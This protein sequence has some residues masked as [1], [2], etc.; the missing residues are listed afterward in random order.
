MHAASR[1]RPAPDRRILAGHQPRTKTVKGH[2][3]GSLHGSDRMVRITEQGT[4]L[5]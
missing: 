1:Q 4:L 3:K 2:T 5:N